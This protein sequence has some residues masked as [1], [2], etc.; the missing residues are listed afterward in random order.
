VKWN[1][2]LGDIFPVLCGVRQGGV[3][4]PVLFALY[5][6]GVISELKLHGHGVHIG[7]LFIGCVLYADILLLSASCHGLQQLVNIC[8]VY[9]T[10]W[11]IKFNP[12]K[13]QVITFGG[14]NPCCQIM[15]NSNQVQWVNKVLVF[16]F[17]VILALQI[18]QIFE[19]RFMD[20][21][22]VFY[23]CLVNAQMKWLL[24]I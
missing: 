20:S 13:S 23:L 19:E 12:L 10:K 18:Y 11:D 4:S 1:N 6:D 3:L 7:S 9:G 16:T 14:Q 17:A 2:V 21:L 15:L 5:I 22:I 8:N 24:Y